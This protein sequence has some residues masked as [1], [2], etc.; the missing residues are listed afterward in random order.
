[1]ST[2]TRARAKLIGLYT[3]DQ[4]VSCHKAMLLK[5]H[6]P[7]GRHQDSDLASAS[8]AVGALLTNRMSKV[9]VCSKDQMDQ[10]NC[11]TAFSETVLAARK[12]LTAAV[13]MVS[14]SS[15]LSFE[16]LYLALRKSAPCGPCCDPAQPPAP[17]VCLPSS[18]STA[19]RPC[20]DSRCACILP[21]WIFQ[22]FI[23]SA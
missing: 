5:T 3:R 11:R 20:R 7:D 19:H 14:L 17:S 21:G 18:F 8:P 1:M 16:H 9:V 10:P 13:G 12:L 6:P 22:I 23:L 15:L 4:H 2:I